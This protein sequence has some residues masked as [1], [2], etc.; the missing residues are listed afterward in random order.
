MSSVP[1]LVKI[2]A[3]NTEENMKVDTSILEPVINENHMT[4]FVLEKKGILHSY[5]KIT[6]GLNGPAGGNPVV[7]PIYT[8]VYSLIDRVVLKAGAKVISTTEN[9]NHIM[10]YRSRFVSNE[11]NKYREQML[12]GRFGAYRTN[13]NIQSSG[14]QANS[15]PLAQGVNIDCGMSCYRY[16]A[17]NAA[18]HPKIGAAGNIQTA[19]SN[20]D[21]PSYAKYGESNNSTLQ[22]SIAE[23]FPFLKLG[24]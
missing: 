16:G 21:L 2:G 24:R 11:N 23:M 12:T 4:R 8:G 1:N 17:D 22:L 5:S 18:N 3:I 19:G 15:K 6:V 7:L 14:P 20:T 9:F 10:T 13:N